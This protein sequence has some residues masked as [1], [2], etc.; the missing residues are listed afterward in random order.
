M[1]LNMGAC[2]DA[3][4]HN[5]TNLSS[6]YTPI[7]ALKTSDGYVSV[8][9]NIHMMLSFYELVYSFPKIDIQPWLRILQ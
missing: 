1:F 9:D 5:P 4:C 8:P 3:S 2:S 6:P 7:L